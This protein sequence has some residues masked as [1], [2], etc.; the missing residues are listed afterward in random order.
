MDNRDAAIALANFARFGSRT[1]TKLRAFFA[2]PLDL[3]NASASQLREIGLSEN[4][5]NAFAAFRST[6]RAD[7]VQQQLTAN[8]I[9]VVTI[10][11]DNYPQLLRQ[12]ADPPMTLFVRG[13]FTRLQN[14]PHVA[15]IGSRHCT[16]YGRQVTKLFA[17][18]LAQAG[19]V[20]VSGLAYGVDEA[21]HRTTLDVNGFTL[22]VLASGMLG[23]DNYRQQELI[24]AIIEKRGV[25]ISEFPL[26]ASP[27]KQHFPMRNRIVA[28]IAQ[29]TLVVEAAEKSGSLITAR[30]AVEANRDVF[31]VPGPITSPTSAGANRYIQDGAH[32]ALSPDDILQVLGLGQ[33]P[34]RE[35]VVQAASL[36]Q[37]HATVV[38]A[39]HA[40]PLHIDE[41]VRTTGL[42]ASA[43]NAALTSLE[44]QE[45]LQPLG[46]MRY[47]LC[48]Q[49]E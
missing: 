20:V 9:H 29:A 12:I 30:L 42:P 48:V 26:T 1:L 16:D 7:V 41:I 35:R 32:V 22:A 25:I 11:D 33:A 15:I 13:D 18:R 8:D 3:W 27:R 43:V 24:N 10:D 23:V 6:Y 46:G 38:H 14:L 5:I 19:V 40:A 17:R 37:E 44:L 28:G 49:V 34:T 39:L 45:I 2:T 47:A 36:P 4:G 21:A 31:A